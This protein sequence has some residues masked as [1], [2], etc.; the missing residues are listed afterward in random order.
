MRFRTDLRAVIFDFDGTLLDSLKIN[1]LARVAQLRGLVIPE[2]KKF[3]HSFGESATQII[4]ILWPK[5]N[6]GEL[7]NLWEEIDRISPPPLIANVKDILCFLKVSFLVEIGILTQR[8]S[9]SLLSML[10]HYNLLSFFQPDL[11]QTRDRV[12]Y[13]KPDPRAFENIVRTLSRDFNITKDQT[14]Y[15]GDNIL[16][17]Q[18]ARGA[19]IKFVGVETGSLNR[20]AWQTAGLESK[21]IISDIGW[22]PCWILKH[23]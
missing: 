23:F 18:A 10:R 3:E 15:V 22:I 9:K 19:G 1:N 17:W 5:E 12:S 8:R 4:K 20:F 7:I 13:I 11:I 21:N 16:D 6:V 2:D 14:L